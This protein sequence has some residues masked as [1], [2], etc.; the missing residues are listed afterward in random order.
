MRESRVEN[1]LVEQVKRMGGICLKWVSTQRGVP[2]RVVMIRGKVFFVETKQPFSGQLSAAQ[3]HMHAKMRKAGA[4]VFTAYSQIE[5]DA[6]LAQALS[7][8]VACV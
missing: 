7:T 6:I 5:I 2:D 8:E 1:Y 3:A 4:L